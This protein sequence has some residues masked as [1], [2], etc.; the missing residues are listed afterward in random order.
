[1]AGGLEVAQRRHRLGQLETRHRRRDQGARVEHC[2]EFGQHL[3]DSRRTG[4]HRVERLVDDAGVGLG[5][6]RR[7]A[8]VGL[9][10]LDKL[11]AA[12]QQPQGGVRELPGEGVDDH[13]HALATRDTQEPLTE[14]QVAGGGDVGFRHTDGPQRL[15]LGRTRGRENLQAPGLGELHRSRTHTTG[16]G[17]DEDPLTGLGLGQIPQRVERG[18]EPDR[19]RRGLLERPTPRNRGKQPTVHD[20]DRTP[21]GH[22]THHRLAHRKTGYAGA[23]LQDDPGTFAAEASVVR[24]HSEPGDHVAEVHAHRT[25]AYP[26]LTRR[27]DHARVGGVDDSGAAQVTRLGHLDPPTRTTGQCQLTGAGQA[28][29]KGNHAPAVSS[30]RDAD[31]GLVGVQCH[32]QDSVHIS[33]ATRVQ[34][35]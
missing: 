6:L 7:I 26:H 17:M 14:G 12:R 19:H 34:I 10:H 8:D 35:G 13:V 21:A 9:A 5:D 16:T 28:P 31:L 29:T 32:G 18:E 20:P 1:M 22:Q 25:Q 11:T 15:L 23:G 27:Q 33:V 30:R 24:D 4:V 3:R 2:P